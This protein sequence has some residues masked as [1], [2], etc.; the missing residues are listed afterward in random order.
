MLIL[1]SGDAILNRKDAIENNVLA[2]YFDLYALDNIC[3]W[4]PSF[5]SG[6]FF[7]FL[8]VAS[9]LGQMDLAVVFI[10][11]YG[12]LSKLMSLIVCHSFLRILGFTL[13]LIW[14]FWFQSSRMLI[15]LRIIGLLL[16]SISNSK[17]LLNF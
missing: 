13:T 16:W 9:A 4:H 10:M 14:R 12:M 6:A 17:L 7:S 2:Y 11:N 1:R 5:V 3:I 8:S 15:E